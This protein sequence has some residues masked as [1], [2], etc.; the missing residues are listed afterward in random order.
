MAHLVWAYVNGRLVPSK[1]STRGAR[2]SALQQIASIPPSRARAALIQ[3]LTQVEGVS[4]TTVRAWLRQLG[5]RS[6]AH[7][8]DAGVVHNPGAKLQ[9]EAFCARLLRA[10]EQR[11]K[12]RLQAFLQEQQI[13]VSLSTAYRWTASVR[14]VLRQPGSRWAARV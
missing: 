12:P 14:G 10:G 11:I 13:P 4:A 9:I 1:W 8:S 3:D 2:L 7:R 6:R 5:H